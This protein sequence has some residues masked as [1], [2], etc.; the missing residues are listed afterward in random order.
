MFFDVGDWI[1]YED[2][3]INGECIRGKIVDIWKN[4]S[5]ITHYF[6]ILDSGVFVQFTPHNPKWNKIEEQVL[7]PS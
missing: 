6:A 1:I 3:G 7:I 2:T 5:K 4:K